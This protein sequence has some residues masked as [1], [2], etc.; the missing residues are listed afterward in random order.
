MIRKVDI[1]PIN[2][3][4]NAKLPEKLYN[5]FTRKQNTGYPGKC[6]WNIDTSYESMIL[7]AK[8]KLSISSM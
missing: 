6:G 8:R 4:D 3:N 5:I 1:P 7:K 2:E